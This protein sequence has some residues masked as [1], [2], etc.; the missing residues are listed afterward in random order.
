MADV[1][2]RRWEQLGV[3][4][5]PEDAARVRAEAEEKRWPITLVLRE[6]IKDGQRYRR[7]RKGADAR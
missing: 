2:E 3:T 7:E 1:E 4:L 6:L 5:A